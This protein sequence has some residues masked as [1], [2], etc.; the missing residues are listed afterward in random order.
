MSSDSIILSLFLSIKKAEIRKI[1]GMLMLTQKKK[2]YALKK[3]VF[4]QTIVKAL[5]VK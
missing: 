4:S 2:H 1:M 5:D 3:C